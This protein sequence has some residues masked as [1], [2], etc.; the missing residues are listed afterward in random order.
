MRG[1]I[2]GWRHVADQTVYVGHEHGA[3]FGPEKQKLM[4][5]SARVLAVRWQQYP[6]LVK[7]W[8]EADILKTT[9]ERLDIESIAKLSIEP[10]TLYIGHGYGGGLETYLQTQLKENPNSIVLRNNPNQPGIVTME[11]PN[12]K[13][14]FLPVINTKL[15]PLVN[16][17]DIFK[18]FNIQH[19][20]VQT[21]FGYDVN[22]PIWIENLAKLLEIDYSIMLHDYLTVC[23][24]LRLVQNVTYCGEPDVSD[25]NKCVMNYGSAFGQVEMKDY[26][27]MYHHFLRGA[28]KVQAPSKDVSERL[29]GYF[30]DVSIE[31]SPHEKDIVI[32]SWK[33]SMPYKEG[34]VLKIAVIGS[35]S[36]D[37]GSLL[38]RDCAKYCEDNKLPIQ[39]LVFG[40][41]LDNTSGFKLIEQTN[42]LRI[43]NAYE[44]QNLQSMLEL[45]KCHLFFQP[46]L[47]PETYSYVLS[48]AFK[49]GLWP[50]C[51]DIGAQAERIKAI[52]FGTVLPYEKY[53]DVFYLINSF[54]S[55][56]RQLQNN[57]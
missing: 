57:E 51:F 30:N 43:F 52:N 25:C 27:K 3:S 29:L 1:H 48:H 53:D 56:V 55:I 34:D 6:Q 33:G 35:L 16:L 24:R 49:A 4:E 23:P 20:S 19:I 17:R 21:T 22:F 37:K 44:E 38:V 12:E 2:R 39:F 41:L 32:G 28:S 11:I 18:K 15:H 8:L 54:Q 45:N 5:Q 42:Y 31:V 9:R 50:I 26:R 47:W 10:R 7:Q 46:A 14:F 13:Y 40:N 36:P